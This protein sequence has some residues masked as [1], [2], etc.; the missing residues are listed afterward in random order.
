MKSRQPN[1]WYV[2]A[3]GNLFPSSFCVYLGLGTGVGVGV[4]LGGGVIGGGT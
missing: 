3:L 1:R 4:G 2:L